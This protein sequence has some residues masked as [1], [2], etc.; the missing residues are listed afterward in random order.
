LSES[1]AYFTLLNDPVPNVLPSS[2][3]PTLGIF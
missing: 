3:F 2:Y 1:V